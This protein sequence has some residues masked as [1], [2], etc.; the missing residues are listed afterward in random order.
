M[1]TTDPFVTADWLA[2]HPDAVVVDCRWYLDGRSAVAAYEAGHLP[3]ARFVDLDT[4]LSAAPG[5]AGRHPLPEPAVFSAAMRRIGVHQRSLV[6]GYDDTGGYTAGR[7]W[8]MLDSVGVR[9]FVLAGGIGTYRGEL[10]VGPDAG[11]SGLGSLV[12]D[13]WPPHSFATI[14]DVDRTIG[15]SSVNLVDARSTE[16]FRGAENPIDVRF[17]HIPGAVSVPALGALEAG[18]PRPVDALVAHFADAGVNSHAEVIAYCGSGV[19]ACLDLLALRR[20]GHDAAR[21][22]VGSWSEWGADPQRPL[23]TGDSSG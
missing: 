21:L 14:E 1:S 4:D 22:Y 17:G 7:L 23:E 3:G 9:S 15:D 6:V 18:L 12:V 13:H 19:S 16:R 11:P 5:A 10:E 20:A 8:W 2:D